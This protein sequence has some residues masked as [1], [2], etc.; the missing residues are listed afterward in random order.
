MKSCMQ[1]LS[2]PAHLNDDARKHVEDLQRLLGIARRGWRSIV[3]CTMICLAV[4]SILLARTKTTYRA[5]ARLLVLQQG[6]QPLNFTGN[7]AVDNPLLQSGGGSLTTHTMLIQSPLIVGRAL[8]SAG[9]THLSAGT[10][11]E[12]MNVKLPDETARI[13]DIGYGAGSR[14]EAARVVDAVIESYNQFLRDHYQKNNN[15]AIS[16]IIKARDELSKELKDLER[17]YLEFRQKNPA[18]SADEKGRT[19]IARRLDQWDQMANQMLARVLQV[20]AQLDLGQ[21]LADEGAGT[22]T[23][24]NALSQLG[25]L[26]GGE[27]ITPIIPEVAGG[28]GISYQELEDELSA[29]ESQ[30]RTAELFL[31]SLRA[32]QAA[33]SS[34]PRPADEAKLVREFHAEPEVANLLGMIRKTRAS[35]DMAIHQARQASDPSVVAARRKLSRL[36]AELSLLWQLRRP[37][38]LADLSDDKPVREAE[39]NL[40]ALRAKEKALR[41]QLE[42]D[43]AAELDRLRREREQLARRQA[44]EHAAILRIQEQIARLEGASDEGAQARPGARPTRSLLSSIERSLESLETMRAKVQARFEAELATSKKTEIDQLAEANLRNNLA[45]QRDLFNSVVDQLRQ[46]QLV[47]DYGSVTA[48]TIAPTSVIPVRPRMTSILLLALAAGCGLGVGAAYIADLLESRIRTLAELRSLLDLPVLGMIPQL[49]QEQDA[50]AEPLGLLSHARPGS[51][52]AESYRSARTNLESLRRNRSA[53]VLL[54]TSPH[55]GDGKSTTASNLAIALAHAGRKVLLVDA[56]LRAPTQH[57]IYN[58]RWDRGLVHVL[59]GRL[60][61]HRAVQ[62]TTV[63]NLDLIAAGPEVPNPAELLSSHR[64]GELLEWGRPIYNFIIIDSPSLLGL[65]DPA[66]VAAVVDGILLVTRLGELR[67][68]DIEQV[69][70]LLK[71]LGAPVL[72]VVANG[73]TREQ[74]G[75]GYGSGNGRPCGSA[76]PP[77]ATDGEAPALGVDPHNGTADGNIKLAADHPSPHFPDNQDGDNL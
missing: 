38:L 71:M 62:P 55:S 3:I 13:I 28:P 50:A 2:P 75:Y 52:L 76:R 68:R 65:S 57:A 53:Q 35:L 17:Q 61:A 40:L 12:R 64:L 48:Q 66:I 67:R 69:S 34:S 39:A 59:Q 45:R 14:E 51:P 27:S 8:A 41:K 72:G 24:T 31:E 77:Q 73:A 58:L 1:Q 4:A 9:V 21:K 47:S 23:I 26:G 44:P 70:E 74:L 33:A 6:G 19:F 32:E 56:D 11:V 22:A 29:V 16:L 15:Q 20:R 30:R 42:E 18:Y 37:T 49:P 10:V 25:G 7:A 36:E 63:E 54:A 60:P 46:T 5:T 43:R